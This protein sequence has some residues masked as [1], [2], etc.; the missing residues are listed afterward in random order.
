MPARSWIARAA[1]TA[2]PSSRSRSIAGPVSS[3]ARAS[4]RRPPGTRVL[5]RGRLEPFDDARNPGE[6]SED[7]A[8]ED[9]RG[10]NG[11]LA[12]GSDPRRG[13]P[14][15]AERAGLA[16]ARARMGARPASRWARRTGGVAP[17][18]RAVGRARGAAA[19]V[20]HRVPRDRHRARLGH[21]RFAPGGHRGLIPCV[22]RLSRA[23]ALDVVRRRDPTRLDLQ[24]G[25]AARSWP[26]LRAAT[27]A[28]AALAARACGRATFSWNALAVAAIV[29]TV[30]RPQRA[31][32]ASLCPVVLVRRRD[33][34]VRRIA[35]T[36]DRGARRPAR[37]HARGDRAV[38]RDA[39]RESGR[40]QLRGRVP[41]VPLRT[42]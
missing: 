16:R 24:T 28:T 18:G 14:F 12:C 9:E 19:G 10:L 34:R 6:P 36:L 22:T 8:I 2:R 31:S 29:V 25:G 41:T 27:M 35:G 15:A 21:R 39:A 5:L 23:A 4:P 40:S 37:S 26:A 17:C 32:R 30:A 42:P 3:H 13:P 20:A 11:R 1:A 33:L 7:A 38:D